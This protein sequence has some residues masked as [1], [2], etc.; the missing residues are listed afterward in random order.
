[1]QSDFHLKKN[2]FPLLFT[3]CLHYI[4]FFSIIR[5]HCNTYLLVISLIRIII[6][7]L[8][9]CLYGFS[10]TPHDPTAFFFSRHLM[11]VNF[12]FVTCI[13]THFSAISLLSLMKLT[14]TWSRHIRGHGTDI[15]LPEKIHRTGQKSIFLPCLQTRRLSSDSIWRLHPQ[16]SSF[17]HSSWRHHTFDSF[18]FSVD[19]RLAPQYDLYPPDPIYIYI[20]EKFGCKFSLRHIELNSIDHLV[21]ISFLE[22]FS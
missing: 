22:T 1:M 3:A 15:F 7:F 11:A 10:R 20:W 19:V 6:N 4:Y 12:V 14:P 16:P 21:L 17:L 8:K 9:I 18:L 13:Y 5:I 2:T